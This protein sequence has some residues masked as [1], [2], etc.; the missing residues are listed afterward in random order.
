MHITVVKTVLHVSLRGDHRTDKD[1]VDDQQDRDRI[2]AVEER[3]EEDLVKK[4]K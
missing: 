1:T 3:A 2:N 4:K